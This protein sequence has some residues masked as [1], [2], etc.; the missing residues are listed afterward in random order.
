[1]FS[2]VPNV[3]VQID[4][5]GLV[6]VA[7]QQYFI[8]CNISGVKVLDPSITYRWIKNNG[9]THM[10]TGND[11]KSLFFSILKLSD[12]GEYSC[13]IN[14]HSLYI[15]EDIFMVTSSLSIVMRS[16]LEI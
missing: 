8:T 2:V 15:G 16:K 10:Q 14:I 13:Q 6:P 11:S 1:M 5:G 3:T 7:G 12:A 4:N 9:S